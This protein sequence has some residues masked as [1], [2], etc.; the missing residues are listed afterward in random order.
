MT[1]VA[2][3]VPIGGPPCVWR[4]AAAS[5]V[6]DHYAHHHP[7]WPTIIAVGATDPWSKGETV[8]AAVTTTDTDV[9]VIAD[10]D[11]I[12]D[13]GTL[14]DA[15]DTAT[16]VG[17]AVP[18][19]FVYRQSQEHTTRI[20]AGDA[21]PGTTPT[22]LDPDAHPYGHP[23]RAVRGGG[24]VVVRRDAWDRVAG[25]DP[26]FYGWGGEDK[27]FG[28][29]LTTLVARVPLLP[30]PLFHLW[31]PPAAPYD[32]RRGTPESEA[33]IARYYAAAGDRRAMRDLVNERVVTR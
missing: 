18:F 24:V 30:A 1:T 28:I 19:R 20:L 10:A 12:P 6:I 13:P 4:Q 7:H 16:T 5:Y 25:I 14:T 26:R 31:H 9:Y 17:W 23:M 2:V 29:A 21:A 8:H 32:C 3:I 33:L 22:E 15:V 11:C 27:A